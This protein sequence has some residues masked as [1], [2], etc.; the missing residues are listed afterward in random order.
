ME[1]PIHPARTGMSR[2]QLLEKMVGE[3]T[4]DTA[5]SIV[6]TLS[7]D[8]GMTCE[9]A[10]DLLIDAWQIGKQRPV[11]EF[12]QDPPCFETILMYP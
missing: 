9:Q 7:A 10:S 3:F 12:E 8:T 2:R 6:K 1:V 11:D 5:K 4:L